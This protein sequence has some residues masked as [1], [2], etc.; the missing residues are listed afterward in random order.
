MDS[1][2]IRKIL[3][4][5]DNSTVVVPQ[6]DLKKSYEQLKTIRTVFIFQFSSF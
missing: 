2:T 3:P 1:K 6:I 5:K 4:V